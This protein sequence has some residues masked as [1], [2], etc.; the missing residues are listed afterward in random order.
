MTNIEREARRACKAMLQSDVTRVEYLS[1]KRKR[2]VRFHLADDK[3]VIATYR[4]TPGQAELEARVLPKLRAQ[5]AL[6]PK[7]LAFDGRF[8]FQEDLGK[9]RLSKVLRAGS[10]ADAETLLDAAIKSLAQTH[11]AAKSAK[12]KGH[13]PT[14]DGE[15]WRSTLFSKPGIIG[16]FLGLP[17]PDLQ[18]PALH[19][20]LT[21]TDP[22]F[23]KWDAR[24]PNAIVLDDGQVGWIDW[25]HCGARNRLDDL[26]WLFGDQSCPDFPDV[27]ERL[28]NRHLPAFTDG[29]D[30]GDARDY[31][32]VYGTFHMCVRLGL[33]LNSQKKRGL[34]D[35]D[36]VLED[37]F[38]TVASAHRTTIRASRWA[39]NSPLTSALSPWL[40]DVA[41][42]IESACERK[43]I[44]FKTGK[45]QG[46]P[47][48][49]AK[50]Q[51]SSA[52]QKPLDEPAEKLVDALAP[53]PTIFV[54]IPAY[55]DMECQWTV[56]D[57]FEKAE[58]PERVFVVMCSQYK[59]TE[60]RDCF[61]IDSPNPANTTNLMFSIEQSRG[62]CWA[63]WQIQK[64][65]EGEDY[66]LM[67]DSHMRFVENW[68]TKMIEELD[69]CP[70]D[71]PYIS[72]YPPGY[73]PP[74]NLESSPRLTTLTA[75][76]YDQYGRFRN[77]A[78]FLDKEDETPMPTAFVAGGFFF[79]KGSFVSEVPCDPHIYFSDDEI[80]MA[81]RAF[82]HGWDG[83]APSEI[84]IYHY[85][86][87]EVKK[88]APARPLYWDDNDDWGQLRRKSRAR[89]DYLL[90]G[91]EPVDC[92]EAL[93]EIDAYGH[94]TARTMAEY[95]AFSGIDFKSK[96]VSDMALKGENS[97]T[98]ARKKPA[99]KSPVKELVTAENG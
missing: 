66:A 30:L 13:V 51:L 37:G 81:A 4:A 25:E 87:T 6:V 63:R 33:I 48:S 59:L 32:A 27:E 18:I 91:T 17:A 41:N 8:L 62:L 24:P 78:V 5:G 44:Q 88:E 60:D 84:L 93:L 96:E 46:K 20:R 15:E 56:K 9:N 61:K 50:V 86:N 72:T 10:A 92:P 16:N 42:Q 71:K 74:H 97:L 52:N 23:V 82:T 76:P 26:V 54:Q 99:A 77:T 65:Y 94:G 43:G 67:I 47:G 53:R 64:M 31:L 98:V 19:D 40:S 45:Q 79:S 73:T 7:V 58:H 70:S 29:R 28:L 83:F 22:E 49:S 57:L 21:V 85:Y 90:A 89:R 38:S 39:A 3:T 75:K 68:D 95:E 11:T 36:S 35:W 34:A 55:R 80:T 2:S 14:L 69:R 12:L 1:G